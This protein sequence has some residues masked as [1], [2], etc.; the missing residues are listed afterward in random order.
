MFGEGL[1]EVWDCYWLVKGSGEHCTER[2]SFS[3]NPWFFV[4]SYANWD[5]GIRVF[6]L[7][8]P[9][10]KKLH[11]PL[12]SIA[13]ICKQ[14]SLLQM[15]MRPKIATNG[16]VPLNADVL[17]ASPRV[18]M[19]EQINFNPSIDRTDISF[20]NPPLQQFVLSQGPQN[21][22]MSTCGKYEVMLSNTWKRHCYPSIRPSHVWAQLVPSL[23]G[24]LPFCWLFDGKHL[25]RGWVLEVEAVKPQRWRDER[26]VGEGW[27]G[28][29][30]RH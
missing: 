5:Y 30:M 23:F 17:C 19:P 10:R 16:A 14:L 26:A 3:P 28:E 11:W 15:E 6:L 25:L 9:W 21:N 18:H 24:F 7:C 4:S 13:S 27:R 2:N 12:L 20:T 8:P 29:I 22:C 1:E